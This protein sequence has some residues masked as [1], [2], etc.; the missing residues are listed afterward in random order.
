MVERLDGPGLPQSSSSE[1]ISEI[2]NISMQISNIYSLR[3]FYP[4]RYLPE[5]DWMEARRLHA[6]KDQRTIDLLLQR[7]DNPDDRVQVVLQKFPREIMHPFSMNNVF[8]YLPSEKTPEEPYM[9]RTELSDLRRPG[10][11]GD[12][13]EAAKLLGD[14]PE[15]N[16]TIPSFVYRTNEE[17]VKI[18]KRT[19]LAKQAGVKSKYSVDELEDLS[20][21]LITERLLPLRSSASFPPNSWL[22]FFMYEDRTGRVLSE[23]ANL[24]LGGRVFQFEVSGQ[25]LLPVVSELGGYD[26]I[27]TLIS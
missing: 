20:A 26:K 7:R 9:V 14:V 21:Q 11:L 22:R 8:V 1:I 13:L 5:E 23:A 25:R 4:G 15:A 16:E 24:N 3:D 27:V 18:Q 17:L 2:S 10:I 19:Q 6:L 12:S